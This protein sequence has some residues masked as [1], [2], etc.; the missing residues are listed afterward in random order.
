MKV[1]HIRPSQDL[2]QLALQALQEAPA[3]LYLPG[4]TGRVISKF[5][6]STAFAESELL[7]FLMFT[8]TYIRALLD[9]GYRDA[10]ANRDALVELFTD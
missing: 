8:P 7:G 1:C 10:Q 6:G 2:H 5:L 3:E 9:L 4:L